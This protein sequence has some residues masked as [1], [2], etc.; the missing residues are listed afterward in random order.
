MR[1]SVVL[2]ASVAVLAAHGVEWLRRPVVGGVAP[3]AAAVL[4][5]LALSTGA[6]V[7]LI[8]YRPAIRALGLGEF[9][10]QQIYRFVTLL[11]ASLALAPE[12]MPRP[13]WLAWSAVVLIGI[14]LVSAARGFNP[15]LRPDRLYPSTPGL[16]FVARELGAGRLA[17]A[18]PFPST[19]FL[20]GHV[21]PVYGLRMVTG[22][23]FH[24][25]DAY[26]RFIARADGNR[27]FTGRQ[28]FHVLLT[29][30]DRL[31]LRLLG[32]LST[33][34]IVTPPLDSTPRADGYQPLPD[35]IGGRILRQP[36]LV[37]QDNLRRVDVLT[38]TRR[39]S[40]VGSLTHRG[41]PTMI[42]SRFNSSPL[43]RRRAVAFRSKWWVSARPKGRP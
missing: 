6:A 16:E 12:P 41:C 26:Q 40:N 20:E 17:P 29:S 43:P 39:R 11:A 2:A 13:R 15:T 25:D 27:P 10:W 19:S 3:L 5:A 37:R 9:E 34:L 35:L 28:W 33:T 36:F 7:A 24:G 4:T 30:P 18:D 42:G 21:F 32:L 23:D 31:D 22:Y 1:W 8:A 14:D 38:A